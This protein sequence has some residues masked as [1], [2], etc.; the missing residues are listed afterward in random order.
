MSI[1]PVSKKLQE[2][3]EKELNEIPSRRQE[4]LNHL[5]EWIAKQPYLQY[6]KRGK[7]F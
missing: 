6:P 3:A 1:R 5:K 4:D 2:K 7:Y